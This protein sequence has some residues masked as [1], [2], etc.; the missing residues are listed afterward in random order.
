MLELFSEDILCHVVAVDGWNPSLISSMA[1]LSR[2]MKAMTRRHVWPAYC[3]WKA[4]DV[5]RELMEGESSGGKG[6]NGEET[7]E[8]GFSNEIDSESIMEMESRK[9]S[10]KEEERERGRE[11]GEREWEKEPPGGWIALARLLSLCPG[12]PI[13]IDVLRSYGGR[14]RFDD[15]EKL[16][17]D[18]NVCSL[19]RVKERDGLLFNSPDV[20]FQSDLCD[21]E[22]DSS[23][24]YH[25]DTHTYFRGIIKDFDKSVI[26]E[27]LFEQIGDKGSFLEE[28][29]RND[30]AD[31]LRKDKCP[32]CFSQVWNV[33]D[34]M[35]R[36][37]KY[38]AIKRRFKGPGFAFLCPKGHFRCGFTQVDWGN[39]F[40]MSYLDEYVDRHDEIYNNN[41]H[42]YG[43]DDLG[44]DY[45]V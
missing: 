42:Y 33:S 9:E 22:Q 5:T 13:V 31:G 35:Q 34:V 3:F 7:F 26:R 10:S 36:N 21:H 12:G 32:F 1:P 19:K 37:E 24:R 43:F 23:F 20:I 15:V 18:N 14:R 28:K 44:D 25:R 27:T 4:E 40:S 11:E 41:D 29:E 45:D 8:I 38:K 2:H 39:S 6:E 30:E 16:H 17:V